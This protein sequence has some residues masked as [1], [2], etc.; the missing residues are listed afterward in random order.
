[1][2]DLDDVEEGFSVDNSFEIGILLELKKAEISLELEESTEHD[3]G[4]L[5]DKLFELLDAALKETD[6][7]GTPQL[8]WLSTEL[9]ESTG[10]NISLDVIMGLELAEV[11]DGKT[12][13]ELEVS[14]LA[15]V[16]NPD[17]PFMLTVGRELEIVRDD[18]LFALSCWFELPRV[19]C[20]G[21]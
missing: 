5:P 19:A 12:A 6:V 7:S 13:V 16:S 9:T 8:F 14:V 17:K 2:F 18:T 3:V 20:E 4:N 1:M 21:A 10:D 15:E 11:A